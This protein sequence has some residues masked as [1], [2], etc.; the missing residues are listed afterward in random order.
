MRLTPEQEI[1]TKFEIWMEQLLKDNDYLL[2]RRNVQYYQSRFAYRQVDLEYQ[3]LHLFNSLVIME[4]KYSH[5]RELPLQLRRPI[6]KA[7]QL[8]RIDTVLDEVEE[9]RL[10]VSARK[11][12]VV[13]NGYFSPEM[14]QELRDYSKLELY[15]Q[16]KLALLDRE[17][18]GLIDLFQPRGGIEEQIRQI[19]LHK[20]QN[21]KLFRVKMK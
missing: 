9:R 21:K 15:D 6:T 5:H 19:D 18:R 8:Q 20:Y 12:V 16:R 14:W 11:A 7:G 3:D 1:G 13:T 10:F 4:L 2:V 17:R